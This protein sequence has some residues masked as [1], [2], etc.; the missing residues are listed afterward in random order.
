M[1]SEFKHHRRR[2][3]K[4]NIGQRTDNGK[5]SCVRM[6]LGGSN[7][8]RPPPNHL[9]RASVGLGREWPYDDAP[10]HHR[11]RG[12]LELCTIVESS[13]YESRT[14]WLSRCAKSFA[15]SYKW[16]SAASRQLLDGSTLLRTLL[17]WQQAVFQELAL[18][19]QRDNDTD[20]WR[21]GFPKLEG[22][23]RLRDT[24]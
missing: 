4:Q 2:T 13:E 6:W 21:G 22:Q 8:G 16:S 17:R 20:G 23:G 18:S 14:L 9:R 1:L 12:L 5:K 10:K 19:E 11:Q 24:G 7:P 3:K 15:V